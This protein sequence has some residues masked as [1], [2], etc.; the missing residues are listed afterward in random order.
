[1]LKIVDGPKADPARILLICAGET[2]SSRANAASLLIWKRSRSVSSSFG[3]FVNS[4]P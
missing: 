4:A 1:M 2:S 3:T